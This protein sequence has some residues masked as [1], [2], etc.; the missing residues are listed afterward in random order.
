MANS[1][2][3]VPRSAQPQSPEIR[4]SKHAYALMWQRWQEFIDFQALKSVTSSFLRS[5]ALTPSLTQLECFTVS[6]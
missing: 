3:P 1:D 6:I 4:A 5:G 2:T